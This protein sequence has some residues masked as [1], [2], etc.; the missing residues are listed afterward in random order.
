LARALLWIGFALAAPPF[1]AQQTPTTPSNI[2]EAHKAGLRVSGHI[3]AYM[4]ASQ[5][6]KLSCDEIQHVNFLILN[7]FPDVKETQTRLRI[8]E[9]AKLGA[10]LNLASSDVQGLVPLLLKAYHTAI[11]PTMSIFEGQYTGRPR[12]ISPGYVAVFKKAAG[13]SATRH[14]KWRSPGA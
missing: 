6:V 1:A 5:C 2:D 3:P 14:A 8:T 9:P 11:D 7:F 12:E 4:T 10:D 13:A